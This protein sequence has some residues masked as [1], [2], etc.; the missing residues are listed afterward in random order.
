MISNTEL[1]DR[2]AEALIA[3]YECVYSVNIKTNEYCRYI[4][5]HNSHSLSEEHKGDDFLVI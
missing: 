2:I 1:F 5:E 3:D 4:I